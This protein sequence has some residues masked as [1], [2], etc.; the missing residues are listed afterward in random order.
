ME[1]YQVLLFQARVDFEATAM[2]GYSKPQ[3]CWNLTIRLFSIISRTLVGGDV[4][5]LCREAVYSIA[6][7]DWATHWGWVLHLCRGAVGVP[8]S[9]PPSANWAIKIWTLYAMFIF[10]NNNHYIMSPFRNHFCFIQNVNWSEIESHV[11]N[12]CEIIRM[13]N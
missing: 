11:T 2:K 3:C 5:P 4:L 7:A 1:P 9:L 10:Y 13:I 6:P 8:Y 12:L